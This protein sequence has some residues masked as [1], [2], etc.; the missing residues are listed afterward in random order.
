[1][2]MVQRLLG[3][4]SIGLTVWTAP[5]A[6]AAESGFALRNIGIVGETNLNQ[7]TNF[8]P[9]FHWEYSHPAPIIC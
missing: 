8:A 6:L 9:V 1:M 2:P 5:L 4:V 7:T 3:I